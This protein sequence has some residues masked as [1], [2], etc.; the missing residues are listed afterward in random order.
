MAVTALAAC[1][2]KQASTGKFG[3][4]NITADGAVPVAEFMA[5]AEGPEKKGKVIGKIVKVCQSKGCWFN[6]ETK[7][8]EHVRIITKDHSFSIPKDASGKTAI[9]QGVLRSTTTTVERQK[10]L[11]EDAG[12][13]PE[14]NGQQF[15]TKVEYEFEA[16]G[17]IIQ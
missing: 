10:H 13:N 16:D 17:V 3:D 15:E 2:E 7:E 5:T 12:E 11:A 4:Q 14:A 1:E 8:G 6:L 9:A